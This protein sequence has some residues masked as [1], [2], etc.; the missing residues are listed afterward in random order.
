MGGGFGI[1]GRG[2]KRGQ[3]SIREDILHFNTVISDKIIYFAWN[4][5]KIYSKLY[6]EKIHF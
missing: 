3:T 1:F 6:T 4:R 2:D 5:F